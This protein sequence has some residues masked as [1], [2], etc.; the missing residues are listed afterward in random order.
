[1]ASK[2]LVDSGSANGLTLV[3]HKVITEGDKVMLTYC[4]PFY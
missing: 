4:G 1:M 3:C 2:N